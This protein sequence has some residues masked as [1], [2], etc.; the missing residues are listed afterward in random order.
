MAQDQAYSKEQ[1]EIETQEWLESLDYVLEHDGP[2]RAKV[3]LKALQEHAYQKG[4]R[5]TDSA[6]TP[7]INS[8]PVSEQPPY[9]GNNEIER[10]IRSCI[11]WNAMAMVVRAQRGGTEVGGHISSFASSA[12]LYEV[13][14]NHFFRCRSADYGGDN[15]YIQGHV[16]PGIYSRAFLE[17][18]LT[19]THLQNF[20]RQLQEGGGLPSYPHPRLLPG[21]WQYPTVSMGLGPLMAIYHAR[22]AR[23]MEDRGLK[24]RNG[25]KIWAFVGD[26][27]TDEPETLGAIG[28]AVREKLDN[29][30]FVVNCNLQRLD[31]P[32]RGNGKIIQEL[33]RIFRG[34]GWN[35]IK[36]IW[37]RL[38]DP[39]FDNDDQG[40]LAKYSMEAVDGDFQKYIVKD[41]SYI[42][43][44]FF[45][46]HPDLLKLVS[47]LT[48]EDLTKLNR[49]GHD[50]YKLYSA[51]KAATEFVGA[52]TVIL[53]KTIKG[54]GMGESGEGKNITHQ[55]KKLN[56]VEM[57]QFRSRFNIPLSDD[58]VKEAPFYKPPED[59]IEMQYL[60]K[61]REELGGFLP[62]RN[63]S[64]ISLKIPEEKV[65][66]EFYKG[67][68]DRVVSTTMVAVRLLAKLLKDKEVGKY[69][70]PI[71]PDEARTFGME[72]LFRSVGIYSSVGQLYEP[73]DSDSLLYYKESQ[74]GQILEEGI[75]EAGSISSFIAAGTSYVNHA[76][77]MIPFYFYYSMFGFQRIG[78]FAWAA[79]DMCCRGFLMGG[80][81]G[82]TTLNGEGLQHQDGHSH[83]LASTIP[84]LITYDPAFSYEIAIIIKDGLRRMYTDQ[85]NIF[86]YI[87][88]QNENYSMPKMPNGVEE[89]I[90]KGM[91]CFKR[92]AGKNT[93]NTVN[94]LG[95]GS[96][97]NC[98]LEAA[99]L[100]EQNY[101]IAVNMWSVT[102]YN[103]LRRDG[104][105]CD[106]W[107]M[108][109]PGK[110]KKIPY[111]LQAMAKE[112]GLFVAASDY[113]KVLPDSIA[114]WVPGKL[115]ALGTDGY[116][117]SETREALRDYFCIDAA[118]ITYAALSGL[119]EDGIFK[120]A[121][122][123]K[124]QKDLKI[125]PNAKYPMDISIDE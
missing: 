112:S 121:D 116:G 30:V 45:G 81:A 85:E 3:L 49:G 76:V 32:V 53:A 50:P 89:G 113:M 114:K 48:D 20:R 87:T 123:K 16:A 67:S 28:L 70:V 68:D 41:G 63:S 56:E 74:D 72:A 46:K 90:I 35:V 106:H 122:L 64:C 39:I 38:W 52:P 23:Y 4:V 75:N 59:S 2:V 44:H 29:L 95:S 109:N 11:R 33:E 100:L 47:H 43:E 79:G 84:N 31:G 1:E 62:S 111:V 17:G 34:A 18:R 69:I 119:A 21:F 80:T 7:Y 58:E 19:E 66:E 9:P 120:P 103:E 107:N 61:R 105:A 78:D 98:V 60:K 124:A 125:N 92:S 91:Y 51:Y 82:R 88:V 55:Q 25:G 54:Y 13:G 37:G 73:V 71:I 93:K 94:L 5:F 40:L 22:F 27:E 115:V 36:V 86:Y 99:D 8:I 15:I 101:Q 14:F 6:N 110:K 57:Q 24:P 10:R 117:L 26:G 77:P 65:F 42:R 104:L 97:I 118:H 83:V 102:S 96:I 12:T 108:M